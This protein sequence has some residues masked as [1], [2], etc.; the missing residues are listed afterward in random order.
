MQDHVFDPLA[1][2]SRLGCRVRLDAGRVVM[3][4]GTCSTA[5]ARR[6]ANGLVLAYEPLLRL[7]LDVGPGDQPRTVR[8][9]LAAGRIEIREGRYRERG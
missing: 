2:L 4:Y 7:Q 5:T 3:D 1:E 8:Q 9:L 6:R